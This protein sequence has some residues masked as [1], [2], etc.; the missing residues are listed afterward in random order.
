MRITNKYNLPEALVRATSTERHNKTG[1]VSATMLLKGVKEIVLTDR[2]WD[3]LED[4]ASRR[5][6]LILGTA[7][8]SIM[9]SYGEGSFVEQRLEYDTGLGMTVTGQV[10]YYDDATETLVDWKT[11]SATKVIMQDFGDWRMQGLIYAWL[12]AKNGYGVSKL[13]FV[14]MM[15]DWSQ[16][17]AMYD[18]SYP[19]YPVHMY[20][21]DVTEADIE[22]IGEF[23]MDKVGRIMEA[24][25]LA[26]EEIAPCS[27]SERWQ[28]PT[29]YAVMKRG[30]A[31]SKK[32]C[33]T[34]AEA[35]ARVAELG[36]DH[37]VEVRHGVSKKCQGYCICREHCDFY[38]M[39][40]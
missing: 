16:S 30:G 1:C 18:R 6:W 20:E 21:Y 31:R 8:H 7:V 14:G 5:V 19:Q 33:L 9:E 35:N 29:V 12:L 13:Q 27:A 40:E 4:D 24:S 26:D 38:K 37:Y 11:C 23:V 25:E 22:T 2:H 17:K 34:E 15:K 28:S 3:E 39:M 36:T 32:N 10:D